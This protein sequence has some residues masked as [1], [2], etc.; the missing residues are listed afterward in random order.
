MVTKVTQLCDVREY[1]RRFWIGDIITTC[2]IY[3]GFKAN[4]WSLG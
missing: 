4:I 3:V 1:C 2:S